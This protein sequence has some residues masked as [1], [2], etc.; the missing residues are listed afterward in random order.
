MIG[1]GIIGTGYWGK[2]HIKIYN[3]LL[4]KEKLI[5]YLKICDINEER[6][7]EMGKLY[8][9]DYTTNIDDIINDKRIT[10]VVIVTPSSTHYELSKLALENN[11]DVVLPAGETHLNFLSDR[12]YVS[13][14]PL[15]TYR[16]VFSA[17]DVFI[18]AGIFLCLWMMSEPEQVT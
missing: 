18:A 4:K 10:A 17:G 16:A 12:F 2:N 7:I 15:S 5:D 9:I 1:I 11:K 6:A 3:S 8:N 13:F 14:A